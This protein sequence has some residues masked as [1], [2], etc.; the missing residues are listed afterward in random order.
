MSRLAATWK[1]WFAMWT[2]ILLAAALLGAAGI[3]TAAG[4]ERCPAGQLPSSLEAECRKLS[5]YNDLPLDPSK[6]MVFQGLQESMTITCIQ[7]IGTITADTPGEFEKFLQ[8]DDAKMT[9]MLELHSP[10][11]DLAAGLK[12]GEMIRKARYNTSIGRAMLLDQAMDVYHYKKAICAGACALAFLGGVT[13]AYDKDSLYGLPRLDA[14]NAGLMSALTAYLKKM[15]ASSELLQVASR[16]SSQEDMIRVPIP[17]A[18][19]LRIIYDP[20]G[21]AVFRVED[22]N[23]L[24]AVKFDFS[25]RQKRYR[26]IVTCVDHTSMLFVVDL[27]NSIPPALR[28][29]ANAPADFIDGTGRKLEGSASYEADDRVSLTA[30]KLPGMTTRSFSG[31]GLR[32]E[33]ISQPDAAGRRPVSVDDTKS[34]VDRMNW[35]DSVNAFRFLIRATNGAK[36]LALVLPDC[37]RPRFRTASRPQGPHTNE[38][39]C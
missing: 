6:P 2:A 11:G 23:G 3:R 5:E 32:L 33:S 19:R 9:S 4:E 30:F 37:A 15:G 12:L 38:R 10:G 26:G 13:R 21:E 31:T 29:I 20:S 16:T 24:A 8:T 18:K 17:R 27:D 22:L 34:L 35:V 14:G 7:A 1:P 25:D 36:T 28:T 39:W